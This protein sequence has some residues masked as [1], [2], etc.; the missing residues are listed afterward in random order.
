[1]FIYYNA[2]IRGNESEKVEDVGC[3]LPDAVE[4][5][6]KFGVCLESLWPYEL[7]R[8]DTRPSDEAYQQAKEHRINEA[9]PLEINLNEMKTCLA[10]GFPFAFGLELFSSFDKASESGVVPAPDPND[11]GRASHGW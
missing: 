9:T 5:L 7:S 1:M 10:Q 4:A 2:R 11:T 6:Q 3:A 8:V